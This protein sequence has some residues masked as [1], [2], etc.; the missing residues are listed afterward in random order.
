MVEAVARLKPPT[1]ALD[2][3]LAEINALTKW[4]CDGPWWHAAILVIATIAITLRIVL[5]FLPKGLSRA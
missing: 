1:P 4:W 2:A 5:G 3:L